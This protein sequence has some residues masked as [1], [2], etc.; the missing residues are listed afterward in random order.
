LH[1]DAATTQSKAPKSYKANAK[2]LTPKNGRFLVCL[3]AGAPA[4][5]AR[6]LRD[7]LAERRGVL[8]K[9]HR[10]YEHDRAFQRPIPKDVDFVIVVK[11]QMGH[12]IEGLTVKAGKTAGIPVVRTSHKFTALDMALRTRFDIQKAP[13]LPLEVSSTAYLRVADEP[14]QV[15]ELP[16]EPVAAAPVPEPAPLDELRRA[17]MEKDTLVLIRELQARL[18]SLGA[19]ALLIEPTRVEFQTEPPT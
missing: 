2:R 8:V 19:T 14:A 4:D 15:I 17:V 11:S 18:P 13:P 1:H 3:M 16:P 5:R 9:Y 7:I 6:E 12:A 10:D